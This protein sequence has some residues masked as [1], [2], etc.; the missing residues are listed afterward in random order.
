MAGE[1]QNRCSPNCCSKTAKN[2][3]ATPRISS[4]Q[5]VTPDAPDIGTYTVNLTDPTVGF[6]PAAPGSKAGTSLIYWLAV[7]YEYPL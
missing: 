6:E 1:K 5:S 3:I 4:A 7:T 2:R